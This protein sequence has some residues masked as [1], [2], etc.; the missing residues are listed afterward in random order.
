MNEFT[1]V[2]GA[3]HLPSGVDAAQR[4]RLG[5]PGTEDDDEG[6]GSPVKAGSCAPEGSE[7][8]VQGTES[9]RGSHPAAWLGL[10]KAKGTRRGRTLTR[11]NPPAQT[12]GPTPG[13]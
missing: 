4:D 7:A 6:T 9:P 5:V 2:Q 8:P 1:I 11:L 10:S 3:V 12:P 13:S